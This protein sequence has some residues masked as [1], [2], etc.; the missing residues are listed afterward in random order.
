MSDF[1]LIQNPKSKIELAFRELEAF[2]R[3]LLAVLL[4]LFG[5]RVASDEAGTLQA[6]AE[7]GIKLHQRPRYPM[8]HRARLTGLAAAI[9]IYHNVEFA[10]GIGQVQRLAYHHAMHFVIKIIFELALV[11][12]NFAGAGPYEDARRGALAAARS[13]ILN[14][15]C[16]Y[17]ISF[18]SCGAIGWPR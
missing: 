13:I 14:R 16:H 12:N 17:R 9:D 11:D 6:R 18:N 15:L 4:A 1:P 8:T 5:A 7:F 3:A 2:A 10:D